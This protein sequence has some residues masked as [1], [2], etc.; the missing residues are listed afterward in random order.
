MLAGRNGPKGG[1][2]VNNGINKVGTGKV[3]VDARNKLLAKNRQKIVDARDKLAAITKASKTDLRQK[4]SAKK[5]DPLR[6][7]ITL[8]KTIPNNLQK[9]V[10]EIGTKSSSSRTIIGRTVEN[11]LARRPVRTISNPFPAPVYNLPP[12]IHYYAYQAEPTY[13]YVSQIISP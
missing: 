4:L 6:K 1:K 13:D 11:E 3:V 2:P 12:P 5:A 9:I 10:R 8:K 7:P